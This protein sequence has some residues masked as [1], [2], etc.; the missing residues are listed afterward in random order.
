MPDAP[1]DP[2]RVEANAD[3]GLFVSMLVKD[4]ELLPAIIDLVD[5]SVDGAR[6]TTPDN[7]SAHHVHLRVT[8]ESFAI[9]D[10]CGGIDLETARKYAFR[11]G[12][13]EEYKGIAGSVGQFGIGMKR[14]LFKLGS[15]FTVRSR[16]ARSSFELHVDVDEWLANDSPDWQFRMSMIDDAFDSA[17]GG[18]GTD[19]IVPSLYPSVVEDFSNSLVLSTLREQIRLRHQDVLEKGLQIA[20]NGEGLTGYAPTLMSGVLLSPVNR[21]IVIPQNGGEVLC[22]LI[23]GIAPQPEDENLD[24]GQAEDFREPGDAGWWLF[25][26]GRLLLHA[27]RTA[28][29]GWGVSQAA[30]HPQYRRFRGYAY[31]T[32]TDANLLPWNTTKTSVD[33]DSRVWRSAQSYM[34]TAMAEVMSA[35]NRLKTE[36][37]SSQSAGATPLTVALSA[38]KPTAL[39]DL[40]NADSFVVPPP[41]ARPPRR[42]N[43]K[44]IQ[45]DIDSKRYK[46]AADVLQT[47]VLSE[48]GRRTFDYFY[49]REVDSES[50]Y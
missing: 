16:S 10:D 48:V 43:L 29:T 25:C 17:K 39:A 21:W 24:D 23:A 45:Y 30:Y 47:S 15:D 27:D 26:N 33:Q 34:K 46:E 31:L 37:Q 4:I 32:S 42:R 50:D 12:R 19:I 20:L 6:A 35:L 41:P 8:A 9:T 2:Y 18:V 14:A 49:E 3:K 1:A 22:H 36:S 7:L 13:P 11:F 38:A 40:P 44:R 28:L 5:N